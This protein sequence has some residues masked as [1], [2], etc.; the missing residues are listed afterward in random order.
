MTVSY[1]ELGLVNTRQ[2]FKDAM[3]GG[4]ARD[5]A[6]LRFAAAR[7]VADDLLDAVHGPRL[8]VVVVIGHVLPACGTGYCQCVAVGLPGYVGV[9]DLPAGGIGVR[10]SCEH[11]G[12]CRGHC[13]GD[14][15]DRTPHAAHDA[16]VH[17]WILHDNEC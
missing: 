7:P 10:A 14:Q 15:R 3:A 11:E 8:V 16:A 9:R 5:R 12:E 4:Y 17:V 13:Y 6:E 1:K 2:M